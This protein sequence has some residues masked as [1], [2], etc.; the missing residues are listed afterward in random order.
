MTYSIIGSGKVGTAL[1]RQFARNGIPVAIANTRDPI[2]LAP[3]INEL[4][5]TV[6]AQPLEQALEADI[7]ILAIP[8]GAHREIGQQ[9]A[10]W[11]NRIIID[12]MNTYGVPPQE[13]GDSAST[14]VVATAFVG[15]RV[16]KTF[17]Q[18][19]AALLAKDPA[20]DGGRQVMFV[21]GRDQEANTTVTQL[22]DQLGFA[23]ISLGRIADGGKLL[24]LGG[25]L[26][27]QNIVKY[28]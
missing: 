15:A 21:W 26:I 20:R 1:A 28:Q 8:F 11:K 18:L 17:N 27:L 22:V 16:V 2:S 14:D 23:S 19:P 6:T 5:N 4:G 10:N 24:G 12:A 3:L 13:L 9:C 7:V 25:P